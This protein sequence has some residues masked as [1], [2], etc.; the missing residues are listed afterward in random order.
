MSRRMLMLAVCA[1]LIAGPVIAQDRDAWRSR[2]IHAQNAERNPPPKDPPRHAAREYDRR[3]ND[4]GRRG[5]TP[6]ERRA[7]DQDLRRA[8]REIYRKGRDNR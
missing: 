8:N 4:N 3:D 7:L 5:M 6:D 1:T 2:H